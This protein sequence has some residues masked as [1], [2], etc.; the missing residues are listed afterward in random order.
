MIAL[1]IPLLNLKSPYYVIQD[2]DGDLLFET[3][4]GGEV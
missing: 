1:N 4:Y 2:A 3:D